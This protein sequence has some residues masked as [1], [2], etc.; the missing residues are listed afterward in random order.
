MS[1]DVL[2]SRF[3]LLEPLGQGGM[4]VVHRARD[5]ETG[6]EVAVKVGNAPADPASAERFAREMRHAMAVRHENVCAV[7]GAGTRE[8]GALFLVMELIEGPRLLD[9]ARQRRAPPFVWVEALRALASGLAAVHAKGIVHR[10]IKPHNVM[11]DAHGK[12]KLLDFGIAR[13]F[14][15]ETVT[16]TGMIVGTAAY[17]SPEQARAEELDERSDLFSAGVTIMSLASRG[18]SRFASTKLDAVQKA[19]AVGMFSPPLLCQYEAAAPPELEDLFGGLFTLRPQDRVQ[20]AESLIAL[21]DQNAVR[22][23]D[24]PALLARWVRGELTDEDA[25]RIDA[26][27]ELSRASKLPSDADGQVARTLALRR[28]SLL[29]PAPDTL[30]LLEAEAT[31]GNF[32]FDTEFD[33]SVQAKFESADLHRLEPLELKRGYELFRRSGHIE[34]ATRVLWAYV[35]ARPD[36]APMLRQLERNL[37]GREKAD[38]SSSG[39]SIAR[40]I[41]T[42]GLKVLEAEGRKRHKDTDAETLTFVAARSGRI[43]ADPKPAVDPTRSMRTEPR[44]QRP[45]SGPSA[46]P[47]HEDA[48]TTRWLGRLLVLGAAVAVAWL[49]VT[50]VRAARVESEKLDTQVKNAAVTIEVDER[51]KLIEQAEKALSANDAPTAIDAATRALDLSISVESGLRALFIRAQ[52]YAKQQDV[53]SARRDLELYLERA[54]DFRDPN[55]PRVKRM[56]AELGQAPTGGSKLE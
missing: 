44:K 11:F 7:V 16:A 5:E 37:F 27:R 56:L 36:D 41:K 2:F 19:L 6:L 43:E 50:T 17:M 18:V 4:G 39:L 26:Q 42:G 13:S 14:A 35:R 22:R 48:S 45:T 51:V 54:T 34:I 55:I 38:H 21:I 53:P 12:L 3:T 30:R 47:S 28:A 40:G 15:D 31:R 10:D 25:L 24:G 23:P 49:L 8:D 9:L 20:N 52:A 1:G 46:P 29:D 33:S 32:R